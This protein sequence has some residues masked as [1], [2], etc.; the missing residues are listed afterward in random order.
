MRVQILALSAVIL[1]G[2]SFAGSISDV[3]QGTT[4]NSIEHVT[5]VRCVT[6]TTAKKVELPT[7]APG[8][9]R[10]EIREVNGE[11]KIFRTEAWMG[12]SP[13]VFVTKAPEGVDND[14]ADNEIIW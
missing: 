9:Q 7:L 3:K 4:D 2:P 13:V 5:C 12:G 11:R 6:V 8:T 10:V 1:A 14:V